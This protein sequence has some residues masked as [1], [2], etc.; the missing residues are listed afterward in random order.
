MS[1]LHSLPY[2][3]TAG[4]EN[5]QVFRGIIAAFGMVLERVG[6]SFHFRDF[7][8]FYFQNP[9]LPHGRVFMWLWRYAF[10][11]SHFPFS[12]PCTP[13]TINRRRNTYVCVFHFSHELLACDR[14]FSPLRFLCATP[15]HSVIYSAPDQLLRHPFHLSL[16]RR[17]HTI[18]FVR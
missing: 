2:D 10:A 5:M 17:L 15:E 14:G 9:L 6:I 11:V 16:P 8:I 18:V 13:T 4:F 1:S 12:L 7:S 3:L